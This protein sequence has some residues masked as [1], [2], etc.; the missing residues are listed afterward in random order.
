MAKKRGHAEEH[1]NLER[2]L[3]SYADFMTLLFATFVVLYALS[4]IDLAKFKE[5][6]VSL[7]RAFS[8]QNVI[9]GGEGVMEQQD[10]T[11]VMTPG[12]T[13]DSAPLPPIFDYIKSQ[14]EQGSFENAKK[15]IEK[16][17]KENPSE[18][19]G[20]DVKVNERGLVFTFV[21]SLL[22]DSGSAQIKKAG[23]SALTKV[24]NIIEAK[25]SKRTI[26]VEGHTDN[27]PIKSALYPSNWEL[28]SARAASIIRFLTNSFGLS[29][30][31]FSAVGYAET[32]PVAPNLT[33]EGRKKNRRV[34][35]I[36]LRDKLVKNEAK[37][38]DPKQ[39]K[40]KMTTP[41]Y[42]T[43]IRIHRNKDNA[44]IITRDFMKEAG[45]NAINKDSY[46]KESQKL[47]NEL[48]M[49]EEQT[50]KNEQLNLKN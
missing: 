42:L 26:R 10:T 22:F 13:E 11:S 45:Q 19:E 3:V 16:L 36:V 38:Y 6:Q 48:K 32:I 30:D 37:P 24:G 5:L 14:M 35:I 20:V 40:G 33:E 25:F 44:E 49:K 21:D 34:E 23:I 43:R 41:S 12:Q 1:E 2:W 7:Q 17:Q 18:L 15:E 27:I 46:D 39:Y 50:R 29:R 9:Q 8:G 4:Q 28:S 47:A 31:K